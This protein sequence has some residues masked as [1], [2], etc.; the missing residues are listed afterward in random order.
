MDWSNNFQQFLNQVT[1]AQRQLF[2]SWTSV[3]P[4]MEN[5]D[6]QSMRESFDKALNFQEQVVSNSLEF[7]TLVTR[8][9]L[10]SQKQFWQNYFNMLRSK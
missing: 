2:K 5:S 7:Q 8:S 1:E 6:T 4:G 9:A 3:I 10:E